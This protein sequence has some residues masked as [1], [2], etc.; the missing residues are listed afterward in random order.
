MKYLCLIYENEKQMAAMSK[1][2][3]EA[4]IDEYFELFSSRCRSPCRPFD[5]KRARCRGSGPVEDL[6]SD[7]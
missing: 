1:G 2:E 3:T 5:K 6:R 4:L 7:R